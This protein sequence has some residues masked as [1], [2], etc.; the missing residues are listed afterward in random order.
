M[1]NGVHFQGVHWCTPL[2]LT[3]LNRQ[4]P[5]SHNSGFLFFFITYRVNTSDEQLPLCVMNM[6]GAHI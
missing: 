5:T 6:C 4:Y 1:V 3:P 2:P